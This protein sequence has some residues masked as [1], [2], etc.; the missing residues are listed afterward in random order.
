[1]KRIFLLGFTLLFLACDNP[2]ASKKDVDPKLAVNAEEMILTGTPRYDIL[3]IANAGGGVL[4]WSI[5]EWPNWIKLSSFSGAVIDD[6]L[7]VRLTTDFSQL[8]Y[9]EYVGVIKITSNGGD[10]EVTVRLSYSPPALKVET[11][12]LNFDRHYLYTSLILSNAGGGELKWQIESLPE[13]LQGTQLSGSV[14]GRPEGVPLRARIKNLSYGSY[15]GQFRVTSNGG[16]ATVK[17]YLNY[18][19]EVEIYPGVGAA[20][21]SLGDSYTMVQNRLGTPDRNWYDRPQKTVFIHHFTY[22]ELGLHFAVKTNSMI[23]F[24]SGKVGYIEVHEPYDGMTEEGL[25]IGSTAAEVIAFYGP[26]SQTA[27]AQW[28][29]NSG[30]IFVMQNDRISAIIIKSED[31]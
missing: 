10:A 28:I 2:T 1:M 31:F 25:G 14:F 8:T 18:E 6:T 22:D 4:K 15:E 19:R 5:T 11:P 30:I 17:V 23:L 9:G 24:G 16:D 27:G 26:P 21:I 12:T 20:N 13:W 7:S 29:Y 3:R